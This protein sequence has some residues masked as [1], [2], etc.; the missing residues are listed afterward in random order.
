MAWDGSGNIHVVDTGNHRVQQFDSDR[1][2][3]RACGSDGE[4]DGQL[5]T[6]NSIAVDADG[7]FYVSDMG[8]HD[9]QALRVV[10]RGASEPQSA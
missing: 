10:P 1:V 5:L 8:R 7:I 3:L 9:A 6:P 4:G 2:F